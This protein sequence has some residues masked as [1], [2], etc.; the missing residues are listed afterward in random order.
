[1]KNI[2]L[3]LIISASILLLSFGSKMEEGPKSYKRG[4]YKSLNELLLNEP[5]EVFPYEMK[6]RTY[7]LDRKERVAYS[8][9]LGPIFGVSDGHDF[10]LQHSGYSGSSMMKNARIKMHV[11]IKTEKLCNYIYYVTKSVERTT[12]NMTKTIWYHH[13]IDDETGEYINLTKERLQKMIVDNTEVYN[14]F[15]ARINKKAHIKKYLLEYFEA[16]ADCKG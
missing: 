11:F 2:I 13:L 14:R 4:I 9:K 12:N 6:G 7:D 16:K 5:S 10:Y 1:M 8:E 15:N 3:G